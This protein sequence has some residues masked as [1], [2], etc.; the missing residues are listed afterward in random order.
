MRGRGRLYLRSGRDQGRGDAQARRA[1]AVPAP[2]HHGAG[3]SGRLRAFYFLYYGYVGASQGFLAPW[4]RG[5]G[6]TGDAIGGIAMAAQLVS[7][8]AGLFWAH[9]ADRRDA[10]EKTLRRCAFGAACALAFLPFAR[11]PLQVGLVLAAHGFF[12]GALIP[13]ADSV[14]MEWAVLEPGRSYARTRLFGSLGFVV[15]AQG[16]GLLLTA[17]GD[18]P[19]DLLMPAVAAV[20]VL[21]YALVARTLQGPARTA[22]EPLTSAAFFPAATR[23]LS[24]PAVALLFLVF[25]FPALLRRFSLS[26]LLVAASAGT[27]VRW[28]LLSR[29]HDAASIVGL[30]LFHALSFGV[31]WAAAVEAMRRSVPLQLRATGQALFSALVFGAGNAIGYGL[32]G[33]GYQRFGSASPLFAFAAAVET[34]ALLFTALAAARLGGV[35]ATNA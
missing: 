5:L 8:P 15:V 25:A 35:R 4:L 6:F 7:A 29:A 28:V 30:Q 11:T 21:G 9:A 1:S 13:L 26:S 34:A 12:G 31:W 23:I 22:P 19:G 3:V 18:R 2:Q 20:S 27:I 10:R 33:A 24:D 32:A 14:T 17:R 16:L